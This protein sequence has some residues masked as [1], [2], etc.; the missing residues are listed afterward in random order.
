M[1]Y[2]DLWNLLV[3]LDLEEI[4]IKYFVSSTFKCLSK[5][6]DISLGNDIRQTF[7][8]LIC[9]WNLIIVPNPFCIGSGAYLLEFD[10]SSPLRTVAVSLNC[11]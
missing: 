10:S 7:R 5:S 2:K 11:F 4:K 1:S 3:L 9:K 6:C 8:P